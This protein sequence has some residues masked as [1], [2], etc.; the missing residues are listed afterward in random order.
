M[1]D[2]KQK[3]DVFNLIAILLILK[4]WFKYIWISSNC[5]E[6]IVYNTN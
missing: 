3:D 2:V 1:E 5:F 4:F 6:D